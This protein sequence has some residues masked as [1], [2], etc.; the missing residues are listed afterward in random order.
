MGRVTKF[1]LPPV[2]V[3][4]GSDLMCPTATMTSRVKACSLHMNSTELTCS[5]LTQLHDACIGHARRRHDL[6]GCSETRSVG[7]QSVRA[8]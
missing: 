2:Q 5:K 7:A 4:T 3:L 6:I 1:Y 8:L